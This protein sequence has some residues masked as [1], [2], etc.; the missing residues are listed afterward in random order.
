[1]DP[2]QQIHVIDEL[3]DKFAV[4][5]PDELKAIGF[6]SGNIDL[7]YPGDTIDLTKVL[8]DTDLMSSV[9]YHAETLSSDQIN[10]IEHSAGVS[11]EVSSDLDSV[12]TETTT[13]KQ[14]VATPQDILLNEQQVLASANKIVNIQMSELFGSKGYWGFFAES[15]EKSMDMMDKDVGFASKTVDEI[16]RAPNDFHEDGIQHFGIEDRSATEKVL[17]YISQTAN[18][19]GVAH[20]KGEKFLDY[21]RRATAAGITL[22]KN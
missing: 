15:W 22:N 3:K 5:S 4:M 6:S 14:A 10:S 13:I 9:S 18:E 17:K 12:I 8:G 11:P 7:I 21:V 16:L 1:M 2:G 19:T 20:E